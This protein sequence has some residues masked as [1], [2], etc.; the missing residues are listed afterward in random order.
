[1]LTPMC[2]ACGVQVEAAQILRIKKNLVRMYSQMTG[3]PT[4]Q[5]IQDLDRDNYL[6]AQEALDHGQSVSP[7]LRHVTH[8]GTVG[9][10]SFML[11][12]WERCIVGGMVVCTDG[13]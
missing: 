5:I 9:S 2:V 12:L 11:W 6:S 8:R 3:R 7:S 10:V 1:V 4:E 13:S